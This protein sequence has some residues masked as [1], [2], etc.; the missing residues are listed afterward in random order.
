MLHSHDGRCFHSKSIRSVDENGLCL[1]LDGSA[2]EEASPRRYRR[3]IRILIPVCFPRDLSI[4]H[5]IYIPKDQHPQFKC[6]HI[7]LFMKTYFRCILLLLVL[8]SCSFGKQEVSPKHIQVARNF[9]SNVLSGMSYLP[10]EQQIQTIDVWSLNRC[11][12]RRN[13]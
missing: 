3:R 6:V 11:M 1:G 4:A 7:F 5:I 9:I 10:R 13:Y 12:K 8:L 2:A